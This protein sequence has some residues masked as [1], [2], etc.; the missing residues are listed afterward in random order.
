M[1]QPGY[2][3]HEYPKWLHHPKQAEPSVIVRDEDE[4]AEILAKW[5]VA[6]DE[7]KLVADNI[8]DNLLKRAEELGIKVD[9]RWSDK[10]LQAEV[11]KH[12]S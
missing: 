5:H 3:H 4:E 10:R 9:A 6:V 11:E 12:A 8:R 1:A 7:V 2:V